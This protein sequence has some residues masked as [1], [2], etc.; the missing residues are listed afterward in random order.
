MSN[1]YLGEIRAFGFNF[2]PRGWALCQGQI[3]AI[4]Q[5]T[6]LFSLLGTNYGG[7]GQTTFALPNLSGRA[8]THQGQGPGLSSYVVGEQVGTETETLLITETPTHG[9]P[10]LAKTV[11]GTASM[12]TTAVAGDYMTRFNASSTAFG[13]MWNNPPL[14]N[15]AT[16]SPTTIGFAGGNQPHENRQPLLVVNYCICT[17]G[18][19]PARN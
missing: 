8:V 15:A 11:T 17:S 6:A 5:N 18:V 2:A 1:P 3:I 9:H 4:S 12:H 14:E 19:F 16:L 10:P 13:Q 7:N